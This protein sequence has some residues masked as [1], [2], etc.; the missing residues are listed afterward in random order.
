[1]SLDGKLLAR[2]KS[3]LD[4]ERAAREAQL[5]ERREDAYAADPRL[6]EIDGELRATVADAIG[7][8]LRRGEDPVEALESV[9]D[10]NLSLQEERGRELLAAGYPMDWLDEKYACPRCRDTGYCGTELCQCLLARY[11]EEQKKELSGLLKLGED[12]FDGF[13]LSLYDDEPDPRTGVSPRRN[14]E[15]VYET[16]REYARKFSADSLNLFLTGGTGLGK[17]FLSTC[18]AK[19]VSERGF[20]V[21]YDTAASVFARYEEDK[22]V[23]S[24]EARA[25]V[26]RYESCDLLILDDLGT[27]MATAFVVSALYTL[28]NTRLAARRKMV[29]SSN[30][31]AKEL[32]GRYSPQI[33]S[34]LCGEFC[35]LKF[36]GR[37]IRLRDK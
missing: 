11:R 28:L 4:A 29:V 20:S 26:R 7:I 22:F 34:R 16:C 6:R 12:D 36:S 17:T 13:D 8:A 33:A 18:I 32:G 19:V 23:R 25:A 9:R 1:M 21:V 3:A 37:D 15:I 31:G 30:L 24:E 5:A 27:E 10:H 35:V 14:M 2:A